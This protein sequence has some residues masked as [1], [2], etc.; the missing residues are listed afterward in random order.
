MFDTHDSVAVRHTGELIEKRVANFIDEVSESLQ[1]LT[2]KDKNTPWFK[3]LK[4]FEYKEWEESDLDKCYSFVLDSHWNEK[5]IKPPISLMYKVAYGPT[6]EEYDGLN[7]LKQWCASDDRHISF[8]DAMQW[9]ETSECSDLV[10][11]H[12]SDSV[13]EIETQ[14]YYNNNPEIF[15]T[16]TYSENIN[17]SD[18]EYEELGDFRKKWYFIARQI[19]Y[20]DSVAPEITNVIKLHLLRIALVSQPIT[21]IFTKIK[22]YEAAVAYEKELTKTLNK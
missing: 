17:K 4:T 21:N 5:N 1:R 7:N 12:L 20:I 22:V 8:D 15:G 13:A 19:D 6:P 18:L 11:E 2:D 9:L 14:E 3:L 10:E 16:S